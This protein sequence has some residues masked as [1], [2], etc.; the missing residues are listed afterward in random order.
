MER[1]SNNS[2]CFCCSLFHFC[3]KFDH[4]TIM[5][6]IIWITVLFVFVTLTLVF[7][8][9]HICLFFTIT[10]C[11]YTCVEFQEALTKSNDVFETFKQEVEKVNL[12]S[13]KYFI[14]SSHLCL[15]WWV[16]FSSLCPFFFHCG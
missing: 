11:S 9:I 5:C 12:I 2:R 1:N 10:V 6:Y 8:W 3:H 4:L 13:L 14:C 15:P 16:E 7:K